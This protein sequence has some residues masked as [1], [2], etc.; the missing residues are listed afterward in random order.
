MN[1]DACRW[2]WRGRDLICGPL[3]AKGE[4]VKILLDIPKKQTI[5]IKSATSKWLALPELL[6]SKRIAESQR[7][8]ISSFMKRA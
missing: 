7:I 4:A 8:T 6:D 5:F 2:W 3:G 1:G